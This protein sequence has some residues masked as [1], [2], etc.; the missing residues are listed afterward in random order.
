VK[1]NILI[2]LIILFV[3]H[4][5]KATTVNGRFFTLTND[6][7]NYTVKLQINTDTGTDDLG[8]ATIIFNFNNNDLS[9]PISSGVNVDPAAYTFHNF[10]DGI[11]YS[12]ANITNPLPYQL[13]I[14]I[15]LNV[16]NNGT[17]VAQAPG[18]W[19]DV[20]TITFTTLNSSG[21]SNLEWQI[22][23][24][25]WNIYDGDN[26]TP[27]TTG[28]FTNENTTPLPVELSSFSASLSD[29]DVKLHWQTATELNN[30]G[31]DIE[32]KSQTESWS[33]I[34]FVPGAGN[35]SSIKNY[36][37][38]DNNIPSSGKLQYRLK[39]ID[40][41]GSFEYSDVAEINITSPE[42]YSLE[43]NY[44]N[45]FNPSTLIRFSLPKTGFVKLKVYN[46][47]GQYVASLVNGYMSEGNHKVNF[48]MSGFPSGVY[49]Y[50]LEVN[51]FTDTKKMVYLR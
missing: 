36:V 34:G 48:D 37:F 6:G 11:F 8:G 51:G 27:W 2:L 25:N 29:S 19:T 49:I 38:T 12:T 14:N 1:N 44:P 43:Q 33:K 30:Y 17:V 47:L 10:N 39:Q 5:N 22:G 28:T 21:S 23:N 45:P 46:L 3:S 7:T 26:S 4:I 20:V 15:V 31:F 32:R 42:N 50:R 24:S 13:W 35:S 40:N 18:N 16:D 9:I 41:D